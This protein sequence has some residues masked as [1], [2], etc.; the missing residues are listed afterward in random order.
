ME[1]KINLFIEKMNQK[2]KDIGMSHSTFKNATG[3][4]EKGQLS[5][6]YDLTLLLLHATLNTTIVKIWKKET[7]T[8]EVHGINQRKINIKN[9]V[10]QKDLGSDYEI[11]GGKTGTVGFIKNLSLLI[12][13]KDEIYLLTVLKAKGDRFNQAQK[14]IDNLLEK[15]PK[16]QIHA[17]AFTVIPYPSEPVNLFK[18]FKPDSL[19]SKNQ[20]KKSNPAS[21][22]KLLTII[23]MFEYPVQLN[24]R[25]QIQKEDIIEDNLN[26]IMVGDVI[27]LFDALHLMLLSSSNILANVVARYTAENYM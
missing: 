18:T 15:G 11:L 9:T 14:I 17:D 16:K 5:T 24:D 2:A 10:Y 12:Y 22:T 26:R 4:T 25:I 27:T 21:I 19:V 3:L 20:T 13:A 1:Q 8:V 6:S 7:Y 23:T